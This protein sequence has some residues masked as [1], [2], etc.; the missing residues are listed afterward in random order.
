LYHANGSGNDYDQLNQLTNF[1]R[2]MLNGTNDTISSPTH[3]QS[4][5]FDALG[6][7]TTFTSDITNQTRTVARQA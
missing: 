4:W 5:A 1:A 6:N 2:G 3:S 7:W